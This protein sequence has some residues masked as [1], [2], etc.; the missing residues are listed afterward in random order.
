MRDNGELGPGISELLLSSASESDP[1]ESNEAPNARA[2]H[3]IK[4]NNR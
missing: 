2:R 1:S 3:K 4:M